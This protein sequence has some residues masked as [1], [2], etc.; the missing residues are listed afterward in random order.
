MR[1]PLCLVRFL[2]AVA[3]A[4]T[5][6]TACLAA[7]AVVTKNA[8]LRTDPSS[9]HPPIRHLVVDDEVEVIA[10]TPTNG[11]FKVRLDDGTEGWV[12]GRSLQV[13]AGAGP[14]PPAP[15][16]PTPGVVATS[17]PQDWEK[18]APN[19]TTFEGVDGSCGPSGDGGD[20]RTNPRK[21]RTD[22]ASAYHDVTWKAIANLQ[23][24]DTTKKS[25][26]DW[27][28]ALRDQIAPFEGVAVRA[29]GYLVAIKVEDKGSGESTNCHMTNASEVDWHMPLVEKA[30]DAEATAIVVETTPRVRQ[31]HPK[32]TPDALAR[33]VNT[34]LPVRIRGGCFSIR[35]TAPT[36]V[37]TVRRCGRSTPSRGSR[38]VTGRRGRTWIRP[39]ERPARFRAAIS[40]VRPADGSRHFVVP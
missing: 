26:D 8:T 40:S 36:S 14:S 29:E 39:R 24:P 10:S 11:Y 6:A 3:S 33:W 2:L 15:V 7:S 28:Q 34:D 27:P 16:V 25:L 31:Q 22:S 13:A 32:W 30:F 19:Q 35:S 37:S 17:L 23:V 20:T 18:P 21:N 38:A 12:Y 9:K 1:L 4:L 5:L